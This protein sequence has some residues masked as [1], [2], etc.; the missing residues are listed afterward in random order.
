MVRKKRKIEKDAPYKLGQILLKANLISR[1]QLEDALKESLEKDEPLGEVLVKNGAITERDLAEALAK[2]KNLPFIDLKNYPIETQA[3]ALI[4]RKLAMKYN[5]IPISLDEENLLVAVSN[6]LDVISLDNLQMITGLNIVP[7]VAEAS[8]IREAIERYLPSEE[9]TL[10]TVEEREEEVIPAIS[11]SAASKTVNKIIAD[12]LSR[13][14]S[15]IHIEPQE[16]DVLVRYRVDGVLQEIMRLPKKDIYAIVSRIKVMSNLNIAERRKPQD[17]SFQVKN[18]GKRVDVR[19]SVLPSVLGES[20]SLR[21]LYRDESLIELGELG[22]PPHILKKYLSL[23]MK[24]TGAILVTGPTGS[25]KTTTLYATLKV[26]A[27]PEKK[28]ITIED[29]V[30][31]HLPGI[32]QMSINPKTGLTFSSGLRTI[33]RA[34]PDIIMVGEIRDVE[35][36]EIAIRASL[37]GHLVL[38]TLH[39]NDAPSALARLMD[40]G[41]EPYLVTSSINAILSQRLARKLCPQCKE[42]YEPEE[43]TLKL[44]KLPLS[45]E[46]CPV[47]YRAKGCNYCGGTGYFGRIGLFEL[48]II[49]PQIARLALEKKTAEEIGRVAQEEGMTTLLQDGAEKVKNGITSLEEI[50][51]VSRH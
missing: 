41:I 32:I 23:A 34:D 20:V 16:K 42:A 46:E 51:R 25:G 33:L 27:T 36:A 30:E 49:T 21:L 38:S 17:G 22:M 44:L 35:T 29:P 19:V 39:T 28:V 13:R 37:T 3:A 45:K 24:P 10:E 1:K 48:M 9:V 5:V 47:I 8:S 12:A 15:D 26:I 50:L 14:A 4:P 40:M 2:Q 6:P 18:E 31:Y 43:E 11:Q 7:V